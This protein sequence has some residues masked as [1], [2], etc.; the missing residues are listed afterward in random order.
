MEELKEIK[1]AFDEFITKAEQIIKKEKVEIL[2]KEEKEYL[3][4]VIRPFREQVE[5]II[6]RLYNGDEDFGGLRINLKGND[7]VWLPLLSKK[8]LYENME[9]SKEYTLEELGLFKGE[10]V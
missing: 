5:S 4:A 6:R 1:K 10:E 2:D 3:E 7:A 8:L 9:N